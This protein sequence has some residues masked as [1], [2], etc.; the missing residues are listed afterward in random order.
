MFTIEEAERLIK[1]PKK[2][3]KN[4]SIIDFLEIDQKFP[5]QHEFELCSPIEKDMIFIYE[6]KQSSKNIY[7][8]T[9]YLFDDE[10]NL[11]LIRIDYNGKHKNPE[12]INDKVPD[13]MRKYKGKWFEY[14]EPHIHYYVEGYKTG[15][16]WAIPLVDD[17]FP[18]K[19]ISDSASIKEAFIEFNSRI[20]LKT[21]ITVNEMLI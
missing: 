15:L 6:I 4:S 9:L 11:G 17:D 5:F 16:E 7:K 2:I 21:E 18:V 19:D 8:M 3:V 20:N 12:Y 10:T 1:L 13:I 14:S